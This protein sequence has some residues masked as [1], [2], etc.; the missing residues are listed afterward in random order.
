VNGAIDRFR[1]RLQSYPELVWREDG[2]VLEIDA[3]HV[4]GF[5]LSISDFGDEYIVT[6]GDWHEHFETAEDACECLIFGLIGPC[7]LETVFRGTLPIKTTLQHLT[8]DGWVNNGTICLLI[9]PFWKKRR[10]VYYTNQ[11][12]ARGDEQL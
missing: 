4:G 3:P 12:P 5:P 1:E 11:I 6:L 9:F 2:G 7:R 10:V 8:P